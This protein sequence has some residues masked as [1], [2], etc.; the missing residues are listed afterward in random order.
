MVL[1][2]P[3]CGQPREPAGSQQRIIVGVSA[4]PWRNTRR[5]NR[6]SNWIGK[7]SGIEELENV[8]P[9]KCSATDNES[10]TTA[11]AEPAAPA[12]AATYAA[13]ALTVAA[14]TVSLPPLWPFGTLLAIYYNYWYS[15]FFV[16]QSGRH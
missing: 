16:R 13:A 15:Y 12:K 5:S 7:L 4:R 6:N 8:D 14:A 9:S 2:I 1:V 10:T 3:E 11:V